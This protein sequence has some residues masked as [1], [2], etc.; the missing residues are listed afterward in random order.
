LID[1]LEWDQSM[2]ADVGCMVFH[3][4]AKKQREPSVSE[5]KVL[6]YL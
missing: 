1:R 2:G 5:I 3:F 4:W 6:V